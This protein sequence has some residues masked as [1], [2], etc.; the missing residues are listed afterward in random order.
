MLINS[1]SKSNLHSNLVIKLSVSCGINLHWYRESLPSVTV[2]C[3]ASGNLVEEKGRPI[4]LFQELSLVL[5]LHACVCSGHCPVNPML[6]W[7][8]EIDKFYIDL[9]HGVCV[10]ML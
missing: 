6:E 7:E 1:T 10:P 3:L 9:C 4:C 5:A 8:R 2:F